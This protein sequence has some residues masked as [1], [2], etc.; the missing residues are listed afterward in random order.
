MAASHPTARL[1]AA[2]IH[3]P[4]NTTTGARASPYERQDPRQV[5]VASAAAA[6]ALAEDEEERVVQPAR[7]SAD[8]N[9]NSSRVNDYIAY[10]DIVN[11]SDIYHSNEEYFRK[12]EE[13]KAAHIKTMAKLRRMYQ[14]KLNLKEVQ[15][16]I[17]REDS[18]SISSSSASGKNSYHPVL[19]VTSLSEPDLSRSS[20]L[21]YTS[22]SEE[23]PP[24][25]EKELS[26]KTKMTY[27]KELINNMWT[28]FSVE[29]YLK[30]DTSDFTAVEKTKKKRKE[31]VPTVTVP[32]PFQMT[33]REQKKK[34]EAKKVMSD[35]EMHKPIKTQD[36]DSECK[37]KFRANPL[38]SYVLLPR[39]QDMVKQN[40]ER[41]RAMKEKNKEALLALQKPFKFIAREEQKR[42]AK[43]KQLRDLF[44]SKKKTSRFK[45]RPIPLSIYG[46]ISPT[47]DKL[48]EE[49]LYKNLRILRAQEFLEALSALSCRSTCRRFRNLKNPEQA[50]KLRHKSRGRCQ[51]P[52]SNDSPLKYK[53]FSE[54]RFPKFSTVYKRF[55]L[56][57]SSSDSAKRDKI[58]ADI[59]ADEENL[60]ETRWPYL[61]PRCKSPVKN[62]NARPPLYTFSPP[63]HTVSSRGR[64]QATRKSE[65]ERMK[66]YRQELEEREE[67]LKQRPLLFERVAQKNARVAA[68]KHYSNTLKAL[69]LS[70]EFVSKKGQSGKLLEYLSN[71]DM[72]SFPEDKESFNE[73]ENIEE[74]ENE[75]D[76]C[77][78]INS[79]DSY[80]EKDEDVEGSGEEN[81]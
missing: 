10:E 52:D 20:S 37:K 21:L 22:S 38:P 60:K 65:K 17:I 5:L 23:E 71:Q 75:E 30:C 59:R 4:T 33:I 76:Y 56:Q 3:I 50:G 14:D 61:S 16:V 73:E 57:T 25:L 69:G 6:A 72:K 55:D 58:L 32:V 12:L 29:D 31:W 26:K 27:A 77:I 53:E 1:A 7:A 8:F 15:P 51:V 9:T 48:K 63:K 39:Y 62:A 19:L 64:E 78:E 34:E 43:E 13:L 2:S 24:K 74:R 28:D 68:E 54:R 40:E 44:K 18:P 35:N 80:Q 41:R 79:Q 49:D 11:F 70:D 45:A 46:Y 36:D 42:A 81:Y 67:K 47:S 66:E